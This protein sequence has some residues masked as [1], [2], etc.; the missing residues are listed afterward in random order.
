MD[1]KPPEWVDGRAFYD[2]LTELVPDWRTVLGPSQARAVS[3]MIDTDGAKTS[4]RV[5][6]RICCQAGL[7]I[8]EIPDDV[9]TDPPKR[10]TGRP[11][12]PPEI[13]EAAVTALKNGE[14]ARQVAAR[15][16]VARTTVNN[17]KNKAA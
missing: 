11:P 7:H 16:G 14:S 13:R 5:V 8:N 2:W 12:A 3:R 10:P 9:W 17:W 1:V 6:D 4:L 15:F